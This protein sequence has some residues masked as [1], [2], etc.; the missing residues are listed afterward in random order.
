MKV[1]ILYPPISALERH[2][3]I[4]SYRGIN[5]LMIPPGI[6][7]L[8]AFLREHGHTVE[9]V[10]AEARNLDVDNILDMI[11][12]FVPDVLG[13]S[14]TTVVF[15]RAVEI[16]ERVKEAFPQITL[17]IGGAHVSAIPQQALETSPFPIGVIGEGEITFLELLAALKDGT[18]LANVQGIVFKIGKGGDR[19]DASN[20]SRP[21]FLGV[22]VS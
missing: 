7:Y 14:A 13:I 12:Q 5:N 20:F 3:N 8:A 6:F 19:S 18:N 17:V 1:F 2:N 10:D 15:H 22:F 16:A 4:P 9:V 21:L 11:A